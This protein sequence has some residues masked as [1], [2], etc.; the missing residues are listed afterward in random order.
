M[1]KPLLVKRRTN[2][3]SSICII[4]ARWRSEGHTASP[5]RRRLRVNSGEDHPSFSG[6]SFY[7][8]GGPIGVLSDNRTPASKLRTIFP[9]LIER[10]Y[11]GIGNR[12][13]CLVDT[14][15]YF[16]I[17]LEPHTVGQIQPVVVVDGISAQNGSPADSQIVQPTRYGIANVC[18]RARLQ[19][20]AHGN[21]ISAGNNQQAISPE[22]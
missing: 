8:G 18:S 5:T 6:R 3:R 14:P 10:S 11:S 15:I 12:H 16:G 21:E 13:R 4:D 7:N 2:E 9:V 20:V 1:R 22:P 17:K 19:A